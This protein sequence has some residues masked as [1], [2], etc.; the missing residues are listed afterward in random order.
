[1]SLFGIHCCL[2]FFNFYQHVVVSRCCMLLLVVDCRQFFHSDLEH[3]KA[4]L[5]EAK[6]TLLD[7]STAHWA[8]QIEITGILVNTPKSLNYI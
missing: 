3:Y 6:H 8:A 7:A 5:G 2:I 1:M 4:C